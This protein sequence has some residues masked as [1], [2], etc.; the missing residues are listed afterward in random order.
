MA[1][2]YQVEVTERIKAKL[3]W[4]ELF[5]YLAFTFYSLDGLTKFLIMY[6]SQ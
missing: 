1:A 4:I 2:C 6:I 3:A 5:L